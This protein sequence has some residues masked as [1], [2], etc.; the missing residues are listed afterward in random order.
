[1]LH[2]TQKI[3]S[4]DHAD[5]RQMNVYLNYY[6]DNE[7]SDLSFVVAKVKFWLNMLHPRHK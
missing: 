5:T 3:D 2:N 1:M 4:F 6:K 7:M